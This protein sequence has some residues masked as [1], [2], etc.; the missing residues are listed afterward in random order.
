[1]QNTID[2]LDKNT[3]AVRLVG[4]ERKCFNAIFVRDGLGEDIIP[5]VS[6]ATCFDHVMARYNVA[7]LPE[8]VDVNDVVSVGSR[9]AIV[10][11]DG[12]TME[13]EIS[14]VGGVSPESPLG[15]AL[16]GRRVGDEV[17]VE[18]PSGSWR[19]RIHTISR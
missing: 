5:A 14:S 16:L 18:A 12:E 8:R 19:A 13:V 10:R 2:A 17:V 6:P 3:R 1:M 11:D 7:W 9:V 4:C 15:K